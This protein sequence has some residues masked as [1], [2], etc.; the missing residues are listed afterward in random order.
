MKKTLEN[1]KTQVYG[2]LKEYLIKKDLVRL[3]QTH[4]INNLIRIRIL[5]ILLIL[6]AIAMPAY[7]DQVQIQGHDKGSTVW[8][9]GQTKGWALL[10]C[11]EYRVDVYNNGGS[12]DT[13]ASIKINFDH[14]GGTSIGYEDLFNFVIPS[15]TISGPSWSSSPSST[16][17]F[18]FYT[19]S[20]VVVPANSHIYLYFCASLGPFAGLY[21]GG[22]LHIDTSEGGQIS[23]NPNDIVVSDLSITKTVTSQSCG[24][25][26]Y[27]I[28]YYSNPDPAGYTGPTS[29]VYIKD[30]YDPTDVQS[31]A[32]YA[33]GSAGSDAAGPFV[34]WGPIS[35]PSVG[36]G[37]ITPF[38]VKIKDYCHDGSIS[39]TV[40]IY[41]DP[42]LMER[43]YVNNEYTISPET[44]IIKDT[45]SPTITCPA[46]AIIDCEDS[47]Y[48]NGDPNGNPNLPK[49]TAI[50]NCDPN[51]VITY[52]DTQTTGC[53]YIITRTWRATDLCG[54]S[55]T[56]VQTITVQDTTPPLIACPP[57]QEVVCLAAI[58]HPY[59]NLVEF[60]SAGGSASDN[61]DEELT[62]THVDSSPSGSPLQVTRTW[63]V[64]D[65]CGLTA[66]CNQVFTI[67][68]LQ[69][70]VD[71]PIAL[72][73]CIAEGF[74]TLSPTSLANYDTLLWE[75][76]SGP[77]TLVDPVDPLQPPT[78]NTVFFVPSP[79]V[80][81]FRTDTYVR[82]TATRGEPCPAEASDTMLIQVYQMP[83]TIIR[84]FE[85]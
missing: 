24:L 69:P 62:L 22:S 72:S 77:G 60:I 45:Q 7:A 28:N 56:C 50:D 63:T 75:I 66:S 82:L 30:Y 10:D 49:A 68:N 3:A 42:A 38:T 80:G 71:L 54:N 31:I 67:T 15:G 34:I 84:V 76:I 20:N 21:P 35:L 4:S 78:H 39:N 17:A 25:I 6:F 64:T 27:R 52:T 65:N 83:V 14:W 57:G 37:T 5:L 59:A 8:T 73:Y 51:P 85:P 23:I 47:I 12:P 61:C 33:G 43:N 11:V 70:A 44:P 1:R 32:N 48:P 2:V 13:Y 53:P 19:W 74:K 58:P 36:S 29:T 41:S 81:D 79:A 18:G 55:A 26:T 40:K 46:N 16:A 9:T